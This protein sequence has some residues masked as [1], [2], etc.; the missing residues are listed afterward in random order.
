MMTKI[1]IVLTAALFSGF[2]LACEIHLPQH[3]VILGD[4]ADFNQTIHHAGCDQE[5]LNRVNTTLSSVEGKIPASQFLEILKLK[6]QV[7]NIRPNLIQVQHMKH[8][9]REQL[10]IPSGVQLQSLEAINSPNYL[11]LAPGDRIEV[12]CIGC[13]Y[14]SK[15]PLNINVI[16]FDG[17]YKSLMIK[18]DFKKMVRAYRVN[19]FLPAFSEISAS[20]LKEEFVEQIPHTDLITDP[21]LLKFYKLNKPVRAGELLRKSDLNALNLVKA[22]LKT[23]VIIENQLLKLKTHGISRSNGGLGDFVEVFHPQKNKKYLGK[24]IDINKVLV[25]L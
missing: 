6:N 19:T 12:E 14:G 18:A 10:S 11:S 2:T 21:E 22:G 7:I 13:L 20:S 4:A 25:E 1:F 23:E 3:L 15:Q 17:T 5:T 16:G 24:V 8:L 9:I